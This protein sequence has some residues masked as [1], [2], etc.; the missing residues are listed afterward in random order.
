M[1]RKLLIACNNEEDA[2]GIESAFYN[3]EDIRLLPAVYSGRQAAD[4]ILTRDVDLL[5]L[6]LFLPDMD[7]LSVLD[8]IGQ[9]SE[10]RRPLVFVMTAL[11]DD[12]LIGSIKDKIVYCFIKPLRY[13]IVQLRVLEL[14]RTAELEE[15]RTNNEIDVLETQIAASVR[16]IGVP[17]HLKGYYY[18]RDAVRIYALSESPVEISITNDI[19]PTV[20]KMYH[21]RPPLVEHAMRTAIEIAWTRGNL[22]TIHAYFGYTINDY[23]GKPSNLEF[24][25]MMAERALTYVKKR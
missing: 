5:L 21:T 13:E 20:A 10:D 19:Y 23:K 2:K 15:S 17:A 16:A 8:F 18:L 14:M 24:V 3:L 22:E 1:Q 6:D 25:A 12:R 11:P 7:G 4:S 9:L